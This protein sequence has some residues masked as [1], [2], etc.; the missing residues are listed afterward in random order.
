M[1]LVKFATG[2]AVDYSGLST[3]DANTLYFITDTRQI[4]KGTQLF[5]GGNFRVVTTYPAIGSAEVNTL[6][7][8]TTDGS[9]EFFDGS[10]FTVVVKP[11]ATTISGTG[12]N[13][14]LATTKAIVDYVTTAVSNIDISAVTTRVTALEGKMTVVQGTGS[15]SIADAISQAKTYTDALKNGAV[16]TNSGNISTL[17]SGKADK[18]TNLSGYGITDAYTKAQTDSAIST[19]IASADHLKRSIATTL[20]A[21]ADADSNTIYMVPK[22]GTT[23]DSYNEYL[24]INGAFEKIGDSTVD[25]TAYATTTQVT[26]AEKE[27]IASAV[28]QSKTYTDGLLTWKSIG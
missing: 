15:G 18:A 19:A 1:A 6:Y 2:T 8:N 22:T 13:N 4:Y 7:I 21:V 24:L 10:A 11:N 14:A 9:V 3:K 27:A 25:L 12:D 23:S 26:S 28:A 17:Q 5:A 20:P 16:A